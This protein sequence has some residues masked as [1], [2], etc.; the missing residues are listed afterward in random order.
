MPGLSR[1][2]LPVGPASLREAPEIRTRTGR[3]LKPLPL[4]VGLGLHGGCGRIRT[5]SVRGHLVYSQARL[6]NS[7]AHPL[8]LR[9]VEALIPKR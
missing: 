8:T 1:L 5:C 7:D 4:P 9:K 6:S 2:P 3:F